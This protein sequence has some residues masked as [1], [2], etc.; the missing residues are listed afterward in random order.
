MFVVG[1]VAQALGHDLEDVALSRNTIHR[2]RISTRKAVATTEQ[3]AFM[4]DCPL[5]LH[6]DVKL[7]QDIAGSK[8]VVDC[9]A[10]IIT[11]G[12][13]ETTARCPQDRSWHRRGAVQ[14]MSPHSGRLDDKAFGPWL[15]VWHHSLKHWTADGGLHT[16]WK[17]SGEGARVD[18]LPPSCV[19]GDADI[20]VISRSGSNQWTRGRSFQ[21]FSDHMVLH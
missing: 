9:V 4:P 8:E 5:L 6:W 3:S 14:C 1:A 12:E 20:C 13:V 18:R 21:M 17:G 19:W 11:G 10:I 15:S 16:D 7:L 2:A